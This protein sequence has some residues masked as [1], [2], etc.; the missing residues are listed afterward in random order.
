MSCGPSYRAVKLFDLARAGWHTGPSAIARARGIGERAN[1][2]GL[3]DRLR[4]TD[5]TRVRRRTRQERTRRGGSEGGRLTVQ[6]RM[7]R[8]PR[9]GDESSSARHD[10]LDALREGREERPQCA[11]P[12][13]RSRSTSG[14][15]SPCVGRRAHTGH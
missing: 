15:L 2:R 12:I 4:R 14:V 3:R 10:A 1:R 13:R 8:A 5:N 11:S 9:F 7:K 6:G